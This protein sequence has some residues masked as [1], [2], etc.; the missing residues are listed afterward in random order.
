M[1]F[2]QVIVACAWQIVILGSAH[3]WVNASDIDN[4]QTECISTLSA[5]ERDAALARADQLSKRIYK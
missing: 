5:P 2:P 3:H 4:Y 1:I